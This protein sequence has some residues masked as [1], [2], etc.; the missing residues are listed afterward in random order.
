[1]YDRDVINQ[2]L[3]YTR[4]SVAETLK[5]LIEAK[6]SVAGAYTP[7]YDLLADYPFRKGK[8]LR[9]TMCISMARA[10]GGFGHLALT[11]SAALE[12][13]HNAFLIHDDLEDGSE[14]RRGKDTL[15]ELVGVPR[16]VNVGDATNVLAV[17]LL[18]E[19]LAVVGVTKALHVLHEIEHMARQSVEGQAMELDWVATNAHDLDDQDYFRMCVKKTCW[20]SFITPCR[21]G[22][23]VGT[24][25]SR[26]EDMEA[27]LSAITRFGMA[28][29]IAFQIQDDL[30]NLE[31]E[32]DRYGK[33]IG[34][35]IYEGKRTMMMNHVLANSGGAAQRILEILSLPR[36]EKTSEHIAFVLD[37]MERAGS[38]DHARAVARQQ[39]GRAAELLAQMVFLVQETPVRTGERWEV[40]V[41][42]RRFLHEL[43][44]YV[45]DRNV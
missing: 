27:H 3:D 2:A 28:L 7:L 8:A 26:E 19:N 32:L 18:V 41:V 10:V 35:D 1:M 33:E 13:Y 20:Y 34:G 17:S 14:W 23:I 22:Y 45:V 21:L 4:L 5:A 15:H 37:Q 39:A 16:A 36:R 38:F 9:P 24:S 44:K 29:G 30:L 40:D 31:G 11:T 43:V 12:L 42:G 25:A 6:R